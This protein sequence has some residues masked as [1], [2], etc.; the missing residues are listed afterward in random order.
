MT[1]THLLVGNPVTG[2]FRAA[3]GSGVRQ[4]PSKSLVTRLPTAMRLRTPVAALLVLWAASET[5]LSLN[6]CSLCSAGFGVAFQRPMFPLPS[7]DNAVYLD[8]NI[9][10]VTNQM[11]YFIELL[12]NQPNY[13]PIIMEAFIRLGIAFKRFKGVIDCLIIKGTEVR[14]PRPVPV[15]YD[16]PIGGKNFKIPRDAVKLNKHLSRN[17]NE[18]ALVIP[19]LKG[20]GAKITTVGG[21]VSGYELFNVIY[22]FDRPLDTQLSVGGKKFKLPK[23]LKLLIKFLAVRPKD[24]LKLE[25]LLLVWKVK[26]QKHPGGGMDVTYAGLKQTVPNVPDVRIKLGKRHYN[27]PTDLQAIFENPQTLHVGQLFEALQRANIKLDVNVRTGVVVGIIVKG[28][29]I[30][31]P[32]TIDLRFKWNNRVYLIPRDM[33]ALIAQL[34]RKGMP[35]DVMHILYTRFGVLQVRNSAGIVIMLTFNGERYRVKVEKQTAVTILGKTFQ[36]PREAE[37][38][39][40][41][42]KADKSRTE[43]MLQAL[44]RAGFMFIPDSSG[45]LQTIQKGAQMIKL[46]LRVRIAINVVGTVYRVPFDL[47]R[48]VKDVRSFGRP[49]INSLLNQLRRVGVK[50]TKQGSKIKILFNSIKY[51]L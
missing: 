41:F 44:Q 7:V 43:P 16:V 11:R 2:E 19:T 25:V 39:S 20:I 10:V 1:H 45:N 18:L 23:D 26:I 22:K 12:L 42:V 24:L 31:L 36:L 17:P 5:S 8:P 35:S 27:I 51:I 3:G 37:K 49:H 50:V 9:K 33:K 6:P 34:E 28:T 38:M 29:A 46:G 15:E 48:L 21:R 30:P 32:L 14:L 4:L 13:L 47:P 40:A